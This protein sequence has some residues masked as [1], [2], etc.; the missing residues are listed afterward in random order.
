[1]YY[2][3]LNKEYQFTQHIRSTINIRNSLFEEPLKAKLIVYKR[4]YA[5]T[6]HAMLKAAD[7]LNHILNRTNKLH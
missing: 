3:L 4:K 6:N 1:M 5:E 2:K 7:Y